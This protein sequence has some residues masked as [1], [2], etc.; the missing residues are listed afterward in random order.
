MINYVESSNK[1]RSQLLLSYFDEVD[2][3]RCG[4]CDVCIER[5]KVELSEFEFSHIVDF[6][7]P[8]LIFNPLSLSEIIDINPKIPENKIIKVIQWLEDNNK[9]FKTT[10]NKYRWL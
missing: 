8:S 10:E 6:I 9:I 4:K 7:K 3:K 2:V 5:N 1:C